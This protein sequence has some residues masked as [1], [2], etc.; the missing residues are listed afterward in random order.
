VPTPARS[1]VRPDRQRAVCVAVLQEAGSLKRKVHALAGLELPVSSH[2]DIGEVDE[3]AAWNLWRLD[4]TPAFIRVERLDHA[5]C[6]FR[7]SGRSLR[8]GPIM[9]RCACCRRN[10][11]CT[12]QGGTVLSVATL[13][14]VTRLARELPEVTEGERHGN[15]TWFVAGKAFAWDR[16]FSKA[17]IRRF[18]DQTPP[19]GPI[20]AVR[21]EDLGEKEAVLAAHPEAFFTIPHFDG[22]S[23]VLIQLPLVAEKALREAIADGWLA[24]APPKLAGQYLNR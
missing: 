9:P 8:H 2:L 13:D 12:S 23:A 17:D 18:G 15:R 5:R 10:G 11:P 16:P 20:L 1:G 14:D 7:L 4:H 6:P 22:Y 21:V 19:E 24:C 3:A